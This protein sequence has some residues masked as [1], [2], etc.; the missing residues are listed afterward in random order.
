MTNNKVRIKTF[1]PMTDQCFLIMT[2]VPDQATAETIAQRLVDGGHAACVTIG[3]PVL[4]LYHWRGKTE[5]APEIPVSI[6][7][8]ARCYDAVES[9]LLELHPYELPEIIALPI[10]AGLPAYLDWITAASVRSAENRNE[11]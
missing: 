3:A 6:K 7:T 8:A 11:A 1:T 5:T 4:S 2:T 10:A 9:V